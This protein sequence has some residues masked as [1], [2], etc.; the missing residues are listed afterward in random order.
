[1]EANCE[2]HAHL[3]TATRQLEIERSTAQRKIH[4][5][6]ECH[7]LDL[8]SVHSNYVMQVVEHEGCAAMLLRIQEETELT[9]R[10]H[11]EELASLHDTIT[12]LHAQLADTACLWVPA[13]ERVR[14]I[15]EQ[16]EVAIE[17]AVSG[18]TSPPSD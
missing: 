11:A 7:E 14:E 4:G 13:R 18:I 9:N 15:R 2:L 1:M 5:L 12:D 6:I 8:K 10:V 16:M 3:E 17:A